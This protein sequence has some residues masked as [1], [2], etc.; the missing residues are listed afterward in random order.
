MLPAPGGP[1]VAFTNLKYLTKL[2]QGFLEERD[3]P[4]LV[5]QALRDIGLDALRPALPERTYRKWNE[6]QE[7]RTL[8]EVRQLVWQEI[9]SWYWT[10]R[11]GGTPAERRSAAIRL[12]KVGQCLAGDLRGYR[13]GSPVDPLKV[14]EFHYR[15]LFRLTHA[16]ALLQ[17]W[18]WSCTRNEKVRRVA[19]AVSMSEQD[20][21]ACLHLS[22]QGEPTIAPLPPEHQ[23]RMWTA[24][25][26]RITEPTVS[27]IL[28]GRGQ[29]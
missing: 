13:G 3:R 1:P 15:M 22:P 8:Q 29:R 19:Q 18:P 28:A 2:R 9:E 24:A 16:L 6:Q 7:A 17:V 5:Y 12:N 10:A 4:S 23:V 21:R 11:R 27:N 14:R 25:A 26:F 20:L